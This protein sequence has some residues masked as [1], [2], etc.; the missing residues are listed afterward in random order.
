MNPN[1][2]TSYVAVQSDRSRLSAQAERGWQAD[3]A[4]VAE[5]P[6]PMTMVAR[7]WAGTLLILAGERLRGAPRGVHAPAT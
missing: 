4:A 5:S 7:R 3:Q 6:R 2:S 1:L